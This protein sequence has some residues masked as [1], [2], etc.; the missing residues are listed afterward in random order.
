MRA[1]RERWFIRVTFGAWG[2][3]YTAVR[4]EPCGCGHRGYT[5]FDPWNSLQIYPFGGTAPVRDS[6]IEV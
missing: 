5:T 2:A 1:Y 6:Y 4:L 3:R